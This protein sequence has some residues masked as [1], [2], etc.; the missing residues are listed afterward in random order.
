MPVGIWYPTWHY[1][2]ARSLMER[3][4]LLH[5][6]LVDTLQ[7]HSQSDSQLAEF[8]RNLSQASLVFGLSRAHS[9]SL[10]RGGVPRDRIVTIGLG[11]DTKRFSVPDRMRARVGP[12]Q[13]LFTGQISQR[14]GIQHL[15]QAAQDF[16]DQIAITMVGRQVG[17]IPSAAIPN[18]VRIFPSVSQEALARIYHQAEVYCLPSIFDAFGLT[19]LE[20]M[21][22]GLPVIGS[23]NTA[24]PDILGESEGTAGVTFRAGDQEDF[25]RQV[26]WALSNRAQLGRMGLVARRIAES[27]DW[28]NWERSVLSLV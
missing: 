14:K 12:M 9:E 19:L 26:D 28:T 21:A 27:C 18:N 25:N 20:A 3:E 17:E 8:D 11:V 13:I 10:A 23:D 7:D 24:A 15:L 4:A 1:N 16:G 22:S 5:P 6:H 2:D